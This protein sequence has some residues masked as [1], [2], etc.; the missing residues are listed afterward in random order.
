MPTCATSTW[1]AC[2]PR[3]ADSPGC[4]WPRRRRASSRP[5]GEWVLDLLAAADLSVGGHLD[6]PGLTDDQLA[7]ICSHDRHCAGSD[8]IYQGQHPHP[9]GYGAF[10][11]LAGYYLA[12]GPETGYQQLARHLATNAADVYGLRDRGRIAPGMAA[13]LCVIGA[14][15]PAAHAT[16]DRPRDLATGVDHVFVNGVLVWP[17]IVTPSRAGSPASSSATPAT[18]TTASCPIRQRCRK[19]HL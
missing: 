2:L 3:A 9:R 19:I 1:A 18:P 8:G 15:G 16:Y 13:D 7:W 14:G 4:R 11:R 10:A 17:G 6:R 5:A 12:A